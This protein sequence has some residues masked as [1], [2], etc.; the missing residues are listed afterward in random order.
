MA[1]PDTNT[2]SLQDVVDEVNPT[3]DDLQDCFSDANPDY[4]NPTYEGSK[5]RLSNFRDYGSHNEWTIEWIGLQQ[6]DSVYNQDT[7][8]S[9]CKSALTGDGINTSS[10]GKCQ[11]EN[12]SGIFTLHRFFSYITLPS[13]S[14]IE[15]AEL[16]FQLD[17]EYTISGYTN[18]IYAVEGTQG[19]GE[20]TTNDYDEFD[21]TVGYFT[22]TQSSFLDSY[23]NTVIKIEANSSD[24]QNLK[25]VVETKIFLCVQ[26]EYD[27]LSST[28][29]DPADITNDKLGYDFRLVGEL[30]SEFGPPTIKIKYK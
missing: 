17:S 11:L 15:Y 22:G 6:M 8:W 19:E 14:D 9:D 27:Y 5:D 25:D 24:I 18:R 12:S 7:S 10:P 1:V 26:H 23:G 28:F 16:Y 2:F 20:V 30:A 21:R 3:T 29:A 4:F 13:L